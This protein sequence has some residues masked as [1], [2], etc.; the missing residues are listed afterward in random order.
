MHKVII[1]RKGIWESYARKLLDL[2]LWT[3]SR[4]SLNISL[5]MIQK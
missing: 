3:S 4:K 5:D 1:A 2:N